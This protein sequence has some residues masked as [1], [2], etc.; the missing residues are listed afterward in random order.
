ML[1]STIIKTNLPILTSSWSPDC[2]TILYSQGANLILQSLNSNS[3]SHQVYFYLVLHL[4][5]NNLYFFF[6]PQYCFKCREPQNSNDYLGI[7][8][9]MRARARAR[10]HTPHPPT[11]KFFYNIRARVCVMYIYIKLYMQFNFFQWHA[12]DSLILIVCWKNN[13][14]LS[15]SEDCRYKV[16]NF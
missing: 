9:I 11:H 4:T 8:S 7:Y 3:K 10:T 12:H 2:S 13:I 5:L 6:F 14:I 16:R 1:R 15:G